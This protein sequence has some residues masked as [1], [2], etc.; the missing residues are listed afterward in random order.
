MISVRKAFAAMAAVGLTAAAFVPA[1]ALPPKG[2]AVPAGQALEI[3]KRDQWV[4]V[5]IGLGPQ[6]KQQ[7][8][9]GTIE[10][11]VPSARPFFVIFNQKGTDHWAAATKAGEQFTLQ[12]QGTALKLS[13]PVNEKSVSVSY[14]FPVQSGAPRA[15]A[16]PCAPDDK[17]DEAVERRFGAVRVMEGLDADGDKV[18][19]FVAPHDDKWLLSISPQPGVSCISSMGEGY[20]LDQARPEFTP[21]WRR[22]QLQP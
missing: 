6:A 1:Q 14:Q 9:E 7:A 21:A 4:P 8:E 20:Y 5:L 17:L 16:M 15:G 11:T 22:H 10:S 19:F 3:L 18:G 2:Q 13:P 12:T